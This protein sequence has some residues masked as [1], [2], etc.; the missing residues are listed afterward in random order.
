MERLLAVSQAGWTVLPLNYFREKSFLV[1]LLHHPEWWHQ[2]DFLLRKPIVHI[3]RV[4]HLPRALLAFGWPLGF[5][6]LPL[7]AFTLL[8]QLFELCEA[9]PLKTWLF[10]G[11]FGPLYEP[12]RSEDVY[13]IVEPSYFFPG[14]DMIFL[15]LNQNASGL[16]EGDDCLVGVDEEE[17]E[18]VGQLEEWFFFLFFLGR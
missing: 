1:E 2:L 15:G 11:H 13:D 4:G 8:N 3:S 12:D 10:V 6:L 5:C 17:E 7:S 9:H 14:L 18:A 16:F